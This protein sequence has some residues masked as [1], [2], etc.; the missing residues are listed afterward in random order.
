MRCIVIIISGC[1]FCNPNLILADKT[2]IT[3]PIWSDY[4]IFKQPVINVSRSGVG[5]D[6]IIKS[7]IDC[8]MDNPDITRVIIS[9]THWE[10]FSVRGVHINPNIIKFLDND[11]RSDTTYVTRERRIARS[12][13]SFLTGFTPDYN[14][15]IRSSERLFVMVEDLLRDIYILNRLCA[16]RNVKLH[17][18]QMLKA[19]AGLSMDEQPAVLEHM[20][21]NKYFDYLE[22][23][24]EIDLIGWPFLEQL[25]GEH[26]E[27]I[28]KST[29]RIGNS[30]MHPNGTDQ[31]KIARVINEKIKDY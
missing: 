17:I 24:K 31:M 1:S 30:D 3:W 16:E 10:R 26:I 6:L 28:L 29:D 11:K 12:H 4:L 7:A 27:A 8:L 14:S 5:N 25:G 20:F 22:T 9:L 2:K 15:F 18:F 21:S 13:L 23:C 19:L